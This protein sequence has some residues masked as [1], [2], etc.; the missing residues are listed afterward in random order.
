M[1]KIQ[2]GEEDTEEA[3]GGKEARED[4][5]LILTTND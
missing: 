3:R 1:K 4:F 2:R 5:E